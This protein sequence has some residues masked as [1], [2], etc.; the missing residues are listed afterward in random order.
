MEG[1]LT[2]RERYV[3]R[4]FDS[5]APHYDA[6]NLLATAGL[7]RLWQRALSAQTGLVS[8]DRALDVCAGTGQ[9]TRLLARR[10]HPG[11]RTVGL[12]FSPE[13]LEVA[14][15]RLSGD[16]ARPAVQLLP[17][18]ALEL[19]F[20]PGTFDA[21]TMG[22]ALRN[23]PHI[24]RAVAEMA[25]VAAPG[26]RVLI[27]ELSRP[28]GRMIRIPYYFYLF[29]VVPRLGRLVELMTG[30][31]KLRPYAYLPH[32]L[33]PLP[34]P[35]AIAEMMRRSGLSGVGYTYLTGG[36]ACLH[37]GVK[38]ENTSGPAPDPQ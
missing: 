19:P 29:R 5:I 33:I 27:L 30:A 18:N 16:P 14:R 13:M 32:S 17:G 26:G 3:R 37:R 9:L 31:D 35:E 22:F 34:D 23:I 21:V 36:I 38:T 24:Q 15:R 28:P 6:F 25:R 12:D 4:I 20:P 10:V 1:N 7:L 2:P 8:G 11:G